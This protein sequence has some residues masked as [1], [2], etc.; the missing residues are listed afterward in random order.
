[1]SA[2]ANSPGPRDVAAAWAKCEGCRRT[3]WVGP[4][5]KRCAG[6]ADRWLVAIAEAVGLP[7]DRVDWVL[8]AVQRREAGS[9]EAEFL[10]LRLERV[11]DAAEGRPPPPGASSDGLADRV[12]ELALRASTPARET[13]PSSRQDARREAIEVAGEGT[14]AALDRAG[15][16]LVW[17]READALARVAWALHERDEAI[18]AWRELD[19]ELARGRKG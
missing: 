10:R 14:V 15:L 12:R 7:P 5:S 9:V 17:S 4:S 18:D 1:V 19:G 8:G 11:I 13:A 3:G 6:C 16:R 2:A